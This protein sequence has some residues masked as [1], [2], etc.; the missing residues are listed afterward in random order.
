MRFCAFCAK[1]IGDED[2]QCPFC[3]KRVPRRSRLT[4]PS[5][6]VEAAEAPATPGAPTASGGP[7]PVA[8][9]GPPSELGLADTL[10][11]TPVSPPTQAT[12]PAAPPLSTLPAAPSTLPAPV[13]TAQQTTLPAA[14]ALAPAQGATLPAPD[15]PPPSAPA[16]TPDAAAA[17]SAQ[18]DQAKAATVT[19]IATA[20]VP[21]LAPMPVDAPPDFFGGVPYAWAVFRARGARAQAIRELQRLN[22]S[23]QQQLEEALR[24]LGRAV[25]EAPTPV[26]AAAHQLQALQGLETR[27]GEAASGQAELDAQIGEIEQRFAQ[28]SAEAQTIIDAAEAEVQQLSAEVTAKSDQKRQLERQRAEL[29]KRKRGFE[30]ERDAAQAKATKTEDAAE[31]EVLTRS[32][33]EQG[34]MAEDATAEIERLDAQTAALVGPLTEQEAT[35][36]VARSRLAEGQQQLGAARRQL[37]AD[38]RQIDGEKRSQG[39]EIARLDREIAD[40]LVNVGAAAESDRGG[41]PGFEELFGRI[42]THR[43]SI[44]TR[45]QSE[46]ALAGERDSYDRGAVRNGLIIVGSGAGTLLLLIVLLAVLL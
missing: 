38:K 39:Q 22:D 32:S 34:V 28:S 45:Q 5:P 23:E 6:P 42:D 7:A 17:P 13:S 3:G 40:Q 9:T 31:R 46:T 8:P 11:A 14:P 1:E 44:A 25:R 20:N 2:E 36:A 19:D 37:E 30:R 41:A 43:T 24:D 21:N 10:F 15:L 33:A 29:D 27:R 12:L 4:G 35:L 16:E 18:P 26:A